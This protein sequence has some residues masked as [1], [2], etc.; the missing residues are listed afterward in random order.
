[1]AAMQAHPQVAAV[2]EQGCAALIN[3][4]AGGDE[5]G[6]A[7]KQRAVEAGALEA[8]VAAL[9]A[10]PQVAA[11]LRA[12]PKVAAALRA[13][14]QVAGVQEQGCWALRN[15]C[16]GTDAAALARA[17]EAGALEA[18]V[19]AMLAHPQVARV[20]ELG[21]AALCSMCSHVDAAALAR[22]Q[23]AAE[24]GALEAVVLAHRIP[25]PLSVPTTTTRAG[26]ITCKKP[27]AEQKIATSGHSG[28]G[29]TD[30]RI[31]GAAAMAVPSSIDTGTPAP[32]V[33]RPLALRP[34]VYSSQRYLFCAGFRHAT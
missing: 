19:E 16:W 34:S 33:P 11:A 9:R 20:Q 6:L 15:M 23:R 18:V 14:P 3:I 29:Q 1:M 13:H 2:Q 17:A 31:S 10:H 30:Q 4:C 32:A 25:D 7:R 28:R 5:A 22:K 27:E 8:A 12:H 21:C 24:A 26:R